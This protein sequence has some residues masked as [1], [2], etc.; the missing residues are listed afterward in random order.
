MIDAK[1]KITLI[2]FVGV[3]M[4]FGLIIGLILLTEALQ[5]IQ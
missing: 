2:S 5:A 3:F 1:K 4:V